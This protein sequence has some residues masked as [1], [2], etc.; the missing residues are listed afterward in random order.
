MT[1]AASPT[2]NGSG[3]YCVACIGVKSRKYGSNWYACSN[4]KTSASE[5][6]AVYKDTRKGKGDYLCAV[7][8]VMRDPD[9]FTC[10]CHETMQL[11]LQWGRDCLDG[12]EG[13][14]FTNHIEECSKTLYQKQNRVL[15]L[16]GVPTVRGVECRALALDHDP[17]KCSLFRTSSESHRAR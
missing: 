1:C 3:A 15:P 5:Q 10:L 7:C 17:E 16:S 4:C 2:C 13:T 6:T 11:F 14:E 8:V 9:N 12:Q